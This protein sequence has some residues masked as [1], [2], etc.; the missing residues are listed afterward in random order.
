MRKIII[1]NAG[2]LIL[3]IIASLTASFLSKWISNSNIVFGIITSISIILLAIYIIYLWN[4]SPTPSEFENSSDA[5]TRYSIIIVDDEFGNRRTR[6][7][8]SFRSYFHGL[9]IQ[10]LKSVNDA[11]VLEAYD[12]VV[13]DILKAIDIREDTQGI[14]DD[15]HRLYPEKYVIAMSQNNS[16]CI[17]LCEEKHKANSSL[18]K[19][20][21]N[22][23]VD[24][25]K[26]KSEIQK[27]IDLAFTELDDPKTYWS[28]IK[29]RF[30]TNNK[31]VNL[32]YD[33]YISFLQKHNNFKRIRWFT[34]K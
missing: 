26:W 22:G 14:F 8:E 12:I 32:A 1:N 10:F 33:R 17:S 6:I 7:E 15:I 2:Q 19:P 20:T 16:E 21:T 31:E 25:E 30:S 27:K 5:R 3:G 23:T 29:K 34:K 4:K 18:P 28:S 24:I 9:D 13:L 11:R